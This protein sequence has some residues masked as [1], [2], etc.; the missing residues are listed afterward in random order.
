[1][2][3]AF[4]VSPWHFFF[5]EDLFCI[6]ILFQFYNIRIVRRSCMNLGISASTNHDSMEGR[7]F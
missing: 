6:F 2:V 1:M 3:V 4:I 5:A 7:A